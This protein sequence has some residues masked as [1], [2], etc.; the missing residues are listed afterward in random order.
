MTSSAKSSGINFNPHPIEANSI[1]QVPQSVKKH[2]LNSKKH[3]NEYLQTFND[4]QLRTSISN[5]TNYSIKNMRSS[6]PPC[7]DTSKTLT[8]QPSQKIK[9]YNHYLKNYVKKQNLSFSPVL[10]I[11]KPIKV[12]NYFTKTIKRN[13]KTSRTPQ[14]SAHKITKRGRPARF[15]SQEDIE[16]HLR[17]NKEHVPKFYNTKQDMKILLENNHNHQLKSLEDDKIYIEYSKLN[18]KPGI[19]KRNDWNWDSCSSTPKN[20]QFKD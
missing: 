2:I 19:I 8:S 9:Q 14:R 3:G 20:V 7:L 16:N 10:N 18:Q 5:Y 11:V 13:L 17:T 12:R 4:I 15:L 1:F 6:S